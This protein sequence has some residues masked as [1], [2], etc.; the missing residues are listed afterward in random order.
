[1]QLRPNPGRK[2]V[3]TTLLQSLIGMS[4]SKAIET[5]KQAGFKG[6]I[7]MRDRK[8]MVHTADCRSDRADLAIENDTVVS[9]KIG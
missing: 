5:L 9:A 4:E 8:G 1:M 3:P 6:R 2:V 7:I